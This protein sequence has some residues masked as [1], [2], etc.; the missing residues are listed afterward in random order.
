MSRAYVINGDG[1]CSFLAAYT[2]GQMAQVKVGSHGG[3]PSDAVLHSS[4]EPGELT[5]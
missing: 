5:Q 1:G 3:Q 2:A 4:R